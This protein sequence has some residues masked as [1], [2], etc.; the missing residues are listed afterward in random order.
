MIIL[1]LLSGWCILVAIVALVSDITQASLGG[2]FQ[3][4]PLGKHIFQLSPTALT[5]AQSVTQR[6]VWPVLW[7]PVAISLLKLPTFVIFGVLAFLLALA[8]RRRKGVNV[9]AN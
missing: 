1:R 6:Y 7:D 9:Y 8:S 3:A 2:S 4:T 5:L